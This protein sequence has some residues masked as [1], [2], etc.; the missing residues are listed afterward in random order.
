MN[1]FDKNPDEFS[2]AFKNT[3]GAIL[4]DVRR[5]DEYDSGH[6]PGAININIQSPDFTEQIENL[7]ADGHYFIYCRSGA[8]S[9]NACL[10]M[11]TL[12]YENVTNLYGGILAWNGEV[13]TPNK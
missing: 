1:P 12:G 3:P 10:Q 11:Q 2:S 4:I 7:S 5:P 8:R 13:N 6:L 9:S